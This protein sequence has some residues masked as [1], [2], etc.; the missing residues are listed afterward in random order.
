MQAG[1][2]FW[3]FPVCRLLSGYREFCALLFRKQRV[4]S[5]KLG[6]VLFPQ[7][8]GSFLRESPSHKSPGL[9]YTAALAMGQRERREMTF[10][11]R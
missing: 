5:W 1:H 9:F 11:G 7:G 8:L 4:F 10:L 6:V 2:I 3:L